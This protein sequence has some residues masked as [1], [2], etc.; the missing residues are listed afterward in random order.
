MNLVRNQQK[1]LYTLLSIFVFFAFL[2]PLSLIIPI[3]LLC[4]MG[5]SLIFLDENNV[6]YFLTFCACFMNCLTNQKAF[7]L[8]SLAILFVLICKHFILSIKNK[9]KQKYW[10]ILL[11]FIFSL[12]LFIYSLIVN[13]FKI[14]KLFQS[15]GLVA[16]LLML[17]LVNN[18]D[19]KK[20]SLILALGLIVSS[21]LSIIS[22]SCGIYI[23][24]PFT[25][26]L[27]EFRFGAYFKY[28]N[29]LALYC[30]LCQACLLSL[31]LTNKLNFK[32]W[33][34]L[35]PII[36]IIG[37]ATLSKS[38][39][40]ITIITYAI[41]ILIG[42]ILSNNKKTYIKIL[43]LGFIFILFAILIAHTYFEK[44]FNRFFSAKQYG[45]LFNVITTGRVGIWKGYLKDWISSPLK[46]LFGS[47]ITANFL[48]GYSPHNLY[49][50][51]LYR[52]GLAG[53]IA[54]ICLL[55][56]VL[57]KH[58]T[59]TRFACYIPILILLINVFFEDIT[60][61]LFTCLPLF[62]AFLFIFKDNKT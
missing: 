14:Y 62:I 5:C 58:K 36:T 59:A 9:D 47:G 11:V 6:L 51:I 18:V 39:I 21:L 2:S 23:I 57:R 40:L 44:L 61:S 7:F 48:D 26:T 25:Y 15:L 42:F 60:S 32:K 20:I 31:F 46:I 24:K 30:A 52:F 55:I 45:S 33:C 56:F 50:A 17:Y 29:A 34:W 10:L 49:I 16:Y 35:L 1:A 28:V 3:F 8:V 54:L 53:I 27:N 37:L 19:I 41:S 12:V 13:N 43:F 38:F 4:L 22:Y